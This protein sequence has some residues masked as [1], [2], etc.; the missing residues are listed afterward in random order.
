MPRKKKIEEPKIEEL[1]EDIK[2]VLETLKTE[3]SVF[4]GEEFI[5]TYSV[6]L[7]GENAGELAEMYANKIG[8]II[9]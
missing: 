5:R 8:G 7:H 3:F 9:K 2:G 6:E 1:K 4:K